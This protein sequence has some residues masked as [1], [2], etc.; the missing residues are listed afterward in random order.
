[1]TGTQTSQHVYEGGTFITPI[2][3]KGRK[4][5][6][7]HLN[8]CKKACEKIQYILIVKTLRKPKIEG[9]IFTLVNDIYQKKYMDG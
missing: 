2:L 7:D 1:M 3:N 8:I 6:H 9:E 5:S 4:K